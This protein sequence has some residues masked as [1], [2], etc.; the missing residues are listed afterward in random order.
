MAATTVDLRSD[1]RTLPDREMRAAMAA[2]EV[3]DDSFGDDPTVL[4][5]E[6]RAAALTGMDAAVF[7]CGGTMSNLLAV[8]ARAGV[9]QDGLVVAGEQAHLVH[10]ENDGVRTLGRARVVTVPDGPFGEL[11]AAAVAEALH[12]RASGPAV[13]CLEN[14]SNRLGGSALEVDAMQRQITPARDAGAAVHL[15]GARLPDAAVALGRSVTALARG[16]DTVAI[17]LCKGLGAPA[18]SVLCGHPEVLERVRYLRRM[19]GGT[20]HQSGVLAAAGLVALSRIDRRADDHRR[21]ALLAERLREVP[22]LVVLQVPHPTNMVFVRVPGVPA[23]TFA[24]RLAECG[25]LGLPVT[26]EDIR[27]VLHA[28]HNDG[29]VEIAATRCARVAAELVAAPTRGGAE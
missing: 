27:F 14:T 17:S 10:Y 25:V 15:D 4:A 23:T 5:L 28:E 1:T 6:E 3:G 29:D 21:A 19:V 2:A 9:D 26:E 12:L 16:V 22:A 11:D 18:G 24:A 13:V 7:T 20:M 8:L